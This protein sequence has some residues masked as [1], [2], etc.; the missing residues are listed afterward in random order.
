MG[1]PGGPREDGALRGHCLCGA[2]TLGLRVVA[3]AFVLCHCRQCRKSAGAPFQAVIPGRREAVTIDDPQGLVREYRSSPHKL[4]A[5]CARCGSPLYSRRDDS[6]TLRLRAGLFDALGGHRPAAHIFATSA[7]EW[8]IIADTLPRHA[9][10]E[11]GRE[12]GA[13]TGEEVP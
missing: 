3:G 1:E 2:V 5:F 10:I 9:D 7:A 4:R 12:P 13:S 11:P 6:A 8:E